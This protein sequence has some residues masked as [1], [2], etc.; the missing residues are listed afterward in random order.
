MVNPPF[1]NRVA[2]VVYPPPELKSRFVKGWLN[3]RL[4]AGF[5]KGW[6][7]P[8]SVLQQTTMIMLFN[9]MMSLLCLQFMI[10][11]VMSGLQ[12][13][14][15]KATVSVCCAAELRRVHP[16]WPPPKPDWY[17]L[18]IEL[19]IDINTSSK[20]IDNM[21]PTS[22]PIEV[23]L[24]WQFMKVHRMYAAEIYKTSIARPPPEPDPLHSFVVAVYSSDS[25]PAFK[26]A[27]ATA[28][29]TTSALVVRVLK[30]L[31]GVDLFQR[32]ISF[33]IARTIQTSRFSMDQFGRW[34]QIH[35]S[36]ASNGQW[37]EYCELQRNKFA[38]VLWFPQVQRRKISSPSNL[39]PTL[40]TS[41]ELPTANTPYL[42]I[43]LG[44]QFPRACE[45]EREPL[46]STM[47]FHP[48][49]LI[50]YHKL[51]LLSGS[52]SYLGL[53]SIL[54]H[55]RHQMECTRNAF[56]GLL[57]P[58]ALNLDGNRLSIRLAE[59]SHLR[60]ENSLLPQLR[61]LH[62]E[63]QRELNEFSVATSPLLF[64]G[65][66]I[67]LDLSLAPSLSLILRP[68]STTLLCHLIRALIFELAGAACNHEF[69][70][71]QVCDP[72]VGFSYPCI[73]PTCGSFA[74]HNMQ[75]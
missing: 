46:A 64:L 7:N 70:A 75:L 14:F 68:T 25:D 26:H 38:W 18:Q 69:K 28:I 67:R 65:C 55:L 59:R 1:G 52:I 50:E 24:Q 56:T 40:F 49:W 63:P 51:D 15:T 66:V 27:T 48:I 73:S 54:L 36:L 45:F 72:S 12:W 57:E 39:A 10:F 34:Q 23:E 8:R 6:L 2:C 4:A 62:L 60:S 3:P 35:R 11:F 9:N 42:R 20:C 58:F 22:L 61:E 19:Q 32:E 53:H 29:E 30:A 21:A 37:Q 43:D 17:Y 31:S 44:L 33:P 47:T 13:G 41:H 5:V 16:L 74:N 71:P